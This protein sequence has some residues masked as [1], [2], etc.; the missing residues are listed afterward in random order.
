ME[1]LLATATLYL[2][3]LEPTDLEYLY[4]WENQSDMWTLG[5]NRSPLS[6]YQLNNYFETQLH[7]P[8]EQMG[9]LRL[10]VVRM[11]DQQVVGCVDLYEYDPFHSR[12]GIAIVI[13]PLYRKMGYATEA[14]RLMEQYGGQVLGLHQIFAYVSTLNQ[15]SISLFN[16]LSYIPVAI[17]REWIKVG[18]SRQDVQIFQKIGL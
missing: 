12:A 1:G 17:L 11:S 15:P 3:A 8:F 7:T 5:A 14:I 18:G 9:E 2:R 6:R 16:R 10:I 13:D 4:R